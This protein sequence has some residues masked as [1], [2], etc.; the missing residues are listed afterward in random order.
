M[1][2]AMWIHYDHLRKARE[3][4]SR[5]G[6]RLSLSERLRVVEEMGDLKEWIEKLEEPYLA[7]WEACGGAGGER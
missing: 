3:A 5:L 2:E 4:R 7:A 1:N 6:A